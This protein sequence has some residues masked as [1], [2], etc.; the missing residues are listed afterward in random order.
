MTSLKVLLKGNDIGQKFS[1]I[2]WRRKKTKIHK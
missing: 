1:K 2:Y